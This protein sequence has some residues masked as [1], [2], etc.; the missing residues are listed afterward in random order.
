MPNVTIWR[1]RVRGHEWGELLP[2]LIL[3][4]DE[5]AA[6]SADETGE[7]RSASRS[8]PQDREPVGIPIEP[9]L[10]NRPA[11]P[12]T[13]LASAATT[14]PCRRAYAG[15]LVR[16]HDLH[17]GSI[18]KLGRDGRPRL[19]G[20]S[21]DD[22]PFAAG[23]LPHRAEPIEARPSRRTV[24]QL[25]ADGNA[26]SSERPYDRPRRSIR[27]SRILRRRVPS[28]SAGVDAR[29]RVWDWPT[30]E[31]AC[32]WPASSS[33]PRSCGCGPSTRSASTTTRPSTP[34]RAPPWP[35]TRST[36]GLFAIF[37]AHPLLVQFL[38]SMPYRIIGVND[39]TPRL[40]AIAF[41]VGG[42][43]ACATPRPICST[44]GAPASSPPRC[45]P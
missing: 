7:R 9:E 15:R 17:A 39:V 30:S 3:G 31:P 19:G 33:R 5:R 8:R 32:C 26:M 44:A 35:A 22:G 18:D 38:F 29:T 12:S 34:A 21:R 37:R 23:R 13:G 25:A 40:I 36:A 11:M 1:L 24:P 42:V 27:S 10:E 20:G 41:G 6:G 45:W 43:A 2:R 16:G 4:D 28:E 14:A